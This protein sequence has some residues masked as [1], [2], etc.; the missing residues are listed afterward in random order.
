MSKTKNYYWDQAEKKVDEII[1]NLK[2]KVIDYDTART[3]IL[4]VEAVSLVDIDEDN[5]DM[6]IAE[7]IQ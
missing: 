4:N 5:V 6:V 3:S 2:N 1:T 7:E